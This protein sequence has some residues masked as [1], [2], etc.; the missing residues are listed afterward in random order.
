MA[1]ASV[2]P[3]TA[4]S[5]GLTPEQLRGLVQRHDVTFETGPLQTIAPGGGGIVRGGWTLD[6]WGQRS[7]MDGKL[8]MSEATHHVHD[9][10]QTIAN[11][12][13][14]S[15]VPG[16]VFAIEPYHGELSMDPR[17]GF[18]EEVRL[19]VVIR[20]DTENRVSRYAEKETSWL[21]EITERLHA[22]GVRR[23]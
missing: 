10:L 23:R 17:R 8:D 16:L 21:D 11:E 2:F 5:E 12:V 7:A 15:D 13:L 18:Q 14:P 22:L 3:V 19:S 9:V 6:L 20:H 1:H 4:F